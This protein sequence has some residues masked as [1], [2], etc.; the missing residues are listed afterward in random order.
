MT[1][2]IKEIDNNLDLT[3]YSVQGDFGLDL[4]FELIDQF[5]QSQHTSNLAW[6]LS[7]ADLSQL[8]MKEI[9]AIQ[10]YAKKYSHY[11]KNGKTAFVMST[12]LN[13][14]VGRMYES[15][16]EVNNHYITHH[17]FKRL[18]EAKKWFEK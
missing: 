9:Q 1:K 6:D 17:V 11:R 18:D 4:I 8:S 7:E 15:I 3:V 12:D 5:Y 10:N 2:V 14:G 16:A 13:F